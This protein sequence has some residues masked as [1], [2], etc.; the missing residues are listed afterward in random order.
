MEQQIVVCVASMPETDARADDIA[1]RL[2]TADIEVRR[3][4]ARAYGSQ[5]EQQ[6]AYHAALDRANRFILVISGG[7]AS[8]FDLDAY[9]RFI[10][11]PFGHPY[12]QIED[13]LDD[14][15][16]STPGNE[17]VLMVLDGARADQWLGYAPYN[18]DVL[19][20]VMVTIGPE[21]LDGVMPA[22]WN[23]METDD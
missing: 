2:R 23:L 21:G 5:D 7:W 6:A 1:A 11:E 19:E 3:Y 10:K 18:K 16:P 13:M 12:C 17:H 22:I 20:N 4:Q 14:T 8:W 9:T 15:L